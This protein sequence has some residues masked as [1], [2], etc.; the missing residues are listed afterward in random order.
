[1]SNRTIHDEA[2][3]VA[4]AEWEDEMD[5]FQVTVTTTEVFF[6]QADGAKLAGQRALSGEIK[7][8]T[9]EVAV[10][11]VSSDQPDD[12]TDEAEEPA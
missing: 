4:S 1:M 11:V 7:P 3:A 5:E 6:V 12:V 10:D 9:S 2:G 8:E